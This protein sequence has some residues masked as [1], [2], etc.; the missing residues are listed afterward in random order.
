MASCFVAG[1]ETNV[2]E[3]VD[4]SCASQ[5][6]FIRGV[7]GTKSRN[8]LGFVCLDCGSIL[9]MDING[10]KNILRR[11]VLNLVKDKRFDYP[12][13]NKGVSCIKF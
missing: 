11:A 7:K 10:T 13:P 5:M 9:N 3:S 8:Y 4:K 12:G 6:C 1:E 2:I